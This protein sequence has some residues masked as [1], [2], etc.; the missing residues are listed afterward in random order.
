MMDD[1]E[2]LS[3]NWNNQADEETN[4]EILKAIKKKQRN[5]K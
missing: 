4:A 1:I 3:E 2:A 5:R